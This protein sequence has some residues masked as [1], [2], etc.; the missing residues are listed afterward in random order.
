MEEK[1]FANTFM[2][3]I[4]LIDPNVS[5]EAKGFY[6]SMLMNMYNKNHSL[7]ELIEK[8]N[9]DIEFIYKLIIE[10]IENGYL[11]ISIKVSESD[12]FFVFEAEK[13]KE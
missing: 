8:S 9:E 1:D 12:T 5:L 3:N 7:S 2:N 4:C 6:Y 11:F 10:L 13:N